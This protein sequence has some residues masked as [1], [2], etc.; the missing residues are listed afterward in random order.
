[1]IPVE[2]PA[3]NASSQETIDH[4]LST[5]RSV[6][7]RLDVERP[8]A[9][10][11]VEECLQLALQA[12]SGSNGQNWFWSLTDDPGTRSSLAA[13]YA[14][15]WSRYRRLQERRRASMAAAEAEALDRLLGSGDALTAKMADVPVLVIPCLRAEL[16][17]SPTLLEM[18]TN[19]GSI[20][21]AVWSFQLALRSRGLGSVLTTIHLWRADDVAEI[22]QLPPDVVQCGLLPVAH[23]MGID[24][25]PAR[26]LP[27]TAVSKWSTS[28]T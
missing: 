8:V 22:L 7:R 9:R 1:M 5:T 6:R 13:V 27:T 3:G 2:E 20:F 28:E 14:D 17:E 18:A 21:P 26:R 25:R 24:F 10:A 23:T 11:T 19:F 16:A 4:L 15:C 12:P